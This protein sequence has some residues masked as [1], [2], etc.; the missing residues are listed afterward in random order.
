[1]IGII[2]MLGGQFIQDDIAKTIKKQNCSFL[3]KDCGNEITLLSEVE[4]YAQTV[5]VIIIHQL[6]L[7]NLEGILPEI[8]KL[9]NGREL[10]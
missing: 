5:D 10:Y 6:M 3:T 7:K 8:R 9:T 4:K 2:S 1:M